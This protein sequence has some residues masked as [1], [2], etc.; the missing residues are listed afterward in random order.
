MSTILTPGYLYWDGTQYVLNS[1]I[2]IVG[3]PGPPGPQGPPGAGSGPAGGDLGGSYPNPYVAKIYGNSVAPT[4]LGSPQ[5]GY[6]L[7]WSNSDNLLE[8]LPPS[9]LGAASGDLSGNYP[10][11]LVIKIYGNPIQNTTLG[12][13]QDGYF[14]TWKNSAG[15]LEWAP[16]PSGSFDANGDLS[17]NGTTQ[18]VIGWDG[19]AFSTPVGIAPGQTLS[20]NTAD[21]LVPT[22]IATN[23]FN[24]LTF[25]ADPTGTNDSANAFQLAI[26]AAGSNGNIV[27]VPPGQYIFKKTVWI[28]QSGITIQG[29]PNIY[30]TGTGGTFIKMSEPY[31]APMFMT[32][33]IS[34]PVFSQDGYGINYFT[35]QSAIQTGSDGLSFI[36]LSE[37]DIGS[38]GG[39]PKL[40]CEFWVN[41]EGFQPGVGQRVPLI[42]SRGNIAGKPVT[43]ALEISHYSSTGSNN[44]L[45]VGITTVNGDYAF[46][47]TITFPNNSYVSVALAYDGS[48]L[49]L[50]I[51]GIF[52]GST[53]ATGNISQ[54][55]HE[56]FSIFAPVPPNT[57]PLN[58]SGFL[59]YN[60]LAAGSASVG[61]KIGSIRLLATATIT[62]NS[63]YI[64]LTSEFPL[65]TSS[66]T[67]NGI[68][69]YATIFL[70]N[71]GT[72]Y[73]ST[74]S[75][76]PGITGMISAISNYCNACV[77]RPF[78]GYY[79]WFQWHGLTNGVNKNIYMNDLSLQAVWRAID[80]NADIQ[81]ITQRVQINAAVGITFFNYAYQQRLLD[82]PQITISSNNA[83]PNILPNAYNNIFSLSYGIGAFSELLTIDNVYMGTGNH[84]LLM[85]SGGSA[86][87]VHSD[88]LYIDTQPNMDYCI[89]AVGNVTSAIFDD[90]HIYW[91][92]GGSGPSTYLTAPMVGLCDVEYCEFNG[93][94]IGTVGG[95]RTSLNTMP[96]I[97][98]IG[99]NP[100]LNIVDTP[101][102]GQ[103]K[104]SV[105]TGVGVSS[106]QPSLSLPIISFSPVLPLLPVEWSGYISQNTG[107]ITNIPLVDVNNPGLI[108]TVNE[109]EQP[110]IYSFTTDGD[111]Y[112]P[113]NNYVL[114]YT[115][116][117]TDENNYLTAD[118]YNLHLPI[119][120]A[121]YTRHFINQTQH[122]INI[123]GP[124][125]LSI[126]PLTLDTYNLYF[127]TV[128]TYNGYYYAVVN[129]GVGYPVLIVHYPTNT[130][131][132]SYFVDNYCTL[133]N[134]GSINIIS[135]SPGESITVYSNG[136]NLVA[137]TESFVPN[138][139]LS[140]TVF[141][142][143]VIGIDGYAIA[144]PTG[145]A[146][147]QALVSNLSNQYVPQG[148]RTVYNVLTYGATNS[149]SSNDAPAIQAAIN[150]AAAVG[151]AGSGSS[152]LVYFPSSQ[153]TFAKY[154][155]QEPLIVPQ[156]GMTLMGDQ[157]N[158]QISAS[159][160]PS[161]IICKLGY[162]G[163][164][165]YVIPI[166]ET[167]IGYQTAG[168]NV[169]SGLVYFM[170]W[171]T[172]YGNGTTISFICESTSSSNTFNILLWTPNQSVSQITFTSTGNAS[173]DAATL[174]TDL[175]NLNLPGVGSIIT[176]GTAVYMTMISGYYIGFENGSSANT[177][178][179]G[180]SQF[181][182][183]LSP[184]LYMTEY[185][186]GNINGLLNWTA[187]LWIN[188]D[189]Y[190]NDYSAIM[191]SMGTDGYNSSSA[192]QWYWN[193]EG[194]GLM[195]VGLSTTG[196]GC[197]FVSTIPPT[198]DGYS[199][200]AFVYDGTD[201]YAYLFV[202]GAQSN[203]VACT[204]T[205]I[206]NVWEDFV[207]A[208]N[209]NE[210]ITYQEY[211]FPSGD[212]GINIYCVGMG[213]FSFSNV[214]KYKAPFAKPTTSI[215]ADATGFITL[216][217][218]NF[219]PQFIYNNF[220]ILAYSW[221]SSL[222][223]WGPSEFGVPVY[224]VFTGIASGGAF[225]YCSDVTIENLGF[226]TD[227]TPPAPGGGAVR[228]V[229]AR[230]SLLK[231]LWCAS[232]TRG[233]TCQDNCYNMV[234]DSCYAAVKQVGAAQSWQL[235]IQNAANQVKVVNFN[236]EGGSYCYVTNGGSSIWDNCYVNP[237]D[238]AGTIAGMLIWQ[239]FGIAGLNG[240]TISSEQG[241]FSSAGI[242]F[243]G[244]LQSGGGVVQTMLHITA[245]SIEGTVAI[246]TNAVQDINISGSY[247]TSPAMICQTNYIT[248]NTVV[249]SHW[250]NSEL[251][252][253]DGY[254]PC[255]R[256]LSRDNQLV[257]IP[258]TGAYNMS[259]N[260][261]SYGQLQFTGTLGG[262]TTV[263]LPATAVNAVGFRKTL[264]NSTTQSLV[265]NWNGGT[266][267]TGI[268]LSSGQCAD[269]R[270]D[271]TNLKQITAS[272]TF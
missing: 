129:S 22:G 126:G 6:V 231:N 173:T 253:F 185:E 17:G 106:A 214:A 36:W 1:S 60:Q 86:V 100:Y 16:A 250:D 114:G 83:G 52:A 140:G 104:L 21:R 201:G 254:M 195:N 172:M 210:S 203:K 97:F 225:A 181:I 227:G 161:S 72:A 228:M 30:G 11:P 183:A 251:L 240:I 130:N 47:S 29:S 54:S 53:T 270:T 15:L 82:C 43:S 31:Q 212:L 144:A 63:N 202:N 165:I 216:L 2:D 218:V 119:W 267:S 103:I 19:Y 266:G 39:L 120:T 91:E 155:I 224:Y 175:S 167:N 123:V 239:E 12:L 191:S 115:Q 255:F 45:Y 149:F 62:S 242:L 10:N 192:F 196:G 71:F 7:T 265:F 133:Q 247:L 262:T 74:T 150:A 146:P 99:T 213:N 168:Y 177:V 107:A 9:T 77:T 230:C 219:D 27:F 143:K 118:G 42:M 235:C 26:A 116:V 153:T 197:S 268:T 89:L 134:V 92:N 94:V 64:P 199:H 142:Q 245:S 137:F 248:P 258:L 249:F 163:D 162:I 105:S 271:G 151:S 244:Y 164:A 178:I 81:G 61:Y 117:I 154:L 243:N 14:L 229:L 205:I 139:D 260:N 131:Y 263:N 75:F 221:I 55:V 98:Y 13:A 51:N 246:I 132:L 93:G 141:S 204:G 193:N 207:I 238:P 95:V 111:G 234:I 59:F 78:T 233:Y 223:T 264:I 3:P 33:T 90:T 85:G 261:W 180:S 125:V 226:A 18:R 73:R 236:G 136:Y 206:Q 76:T 108:T 217:Q 67:I 8:F 44:L 40:Q 102:S 259:T 84:A 156:S 79:V 66:V 179:I 4:A 174:H 34:D 49:R 57:R 122:T 23:I 272:F 5:D 188:L 257:A 58:D 138:G 112:L 101:Y 152:G 189:G 186:T 37:N 198:Y 88:K 35:C 232:V 113:I 48:N 252:A 65:N 25:G 127:G 128:G 166:N 38:I 256:V 200:L 169:G 50:F 147:G 69:S 208:R 220:M 80:H 269:F 32:G 148:V 41:A 215:P 109:Q 110:Q 211:P 145:L 160:P 157:P 222:G 241:S 182:P 190:V 159:N 121:G 28:N 70:L 46:I 187:E 135:L 194:T 158:F 68:S 56:N 96:S 24:V 20:L 124:S 87:T 237:Q 209:N 176:S 171:R 184:A 170:D